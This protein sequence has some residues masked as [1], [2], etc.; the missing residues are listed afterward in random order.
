LFF[1][2]QGLDIG[3]SRALAALEEFKQPCPA[4]DAEMLLSVAR[5]ALRTKVETEVSQS[6]ICL[7]LLLLFCC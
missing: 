4:S 5:C 2:W 7:L 3:R 6:F 1:V